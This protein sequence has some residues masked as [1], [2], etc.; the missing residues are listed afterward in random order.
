MKHYIKSIFNPAYLRFISLFFLVIILIFLSNNLFKPNFYKVAEEYFLDNIINW[1]ITNKVINS[2]EERITII[3][4]DEES[5]EIFGP[6][7]WPRHLIAELIRITSQHFGAK[8]LG[9]DIIF[10]DITETPSDLELQK[11]L[12]LPGVVVAVAFDLSSNNKSPHTGFLFGGY[13]VTESSTQIT[14]QLAHGY[15]TNHENLIKH[16]PIKDNWP[17]IGHITPS[18]SEDGVI[19]HIAPWI[20]YQDHIYPM[21]AISILKCAINNNQNEFFLT[22]FNRKILS[23]D[24][25]N[26]WRIPW[27][28]KIDDFTVISAKDIFSKQVDL[29]LLK[30]RHVI[31][32]STSWGVGDLAVTPILKK[33]PGVLIHAQILS[34]LLDHEDFFF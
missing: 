9:L 12:S 10:T 5:L 30:D 7:P 1:N 20:Q 22:P 17:C 33:T 25:L 34:F 27:L 29:S 6:W 14:S 3:D 16:G 24:N 31:L 15:I 28:K 19:R 11:A 18:I 8:S 21:L 13:K 23:L 26:Q 32:G 4:I 2:T